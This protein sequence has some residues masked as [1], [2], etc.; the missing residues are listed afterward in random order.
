M[1]APVETGPVVAIDGDVP[2]T[3]QLDQRY[4][5]IEESHLEMSRGKVTTLSALTVVV[6]GALLAAGYPAWRIAVFV[7]LA[8]ATVALEWWLSY[9]RGRGHARRRAAL[10]IVVRFSVT[11]L[12]FP[13]T[14][15]LRSPF[16]PVIIFPVSDLVVATGWSRPVK[17][18]L[19]LLAATVL[20]L[21]LL[22]DRWFGPDLPHWAYS[23]IL[24]ALLT[25]AATWHTRYA[26]SL[27]RT[28]VATAYDLRR[29]RQEAVEHSVAR[30]RDM[31]QLA[32]KLSH[33]LKNPLAAI[34]W[35]V[36]L[37]ARSAS[38]SDSREQ[39]RVMGTEVQRMEVILKDYLSFSRPVQVLQPQALRLGA[40][41]DDVLS[42]M[43]GRAESARVALRRRGDAAV[44]ADSRKLKD[45]LFNLLGNALEATPAGGSVEVQIEEKDET[46]RIAVRDSGRGMSKEVLERLGTPFFTTREEGTGLGVAMARATF[47]QHGGSLVYASEPGRGTT[48]LGTLPLKISQ[49]SSHVAGAVG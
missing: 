47:A 40:L 22:P 11:L 8:G 20:A 48:A 21:G 19:A 46:V 38:D 42:A 33:E 24:I 30:A 44:E 29:A 2:T 5:A 39:L 18:M 6:L 35:L 10:A 4:R 15:G 14:G 16:L 27:T 1:K 13:L 37:S 9:T 49:R 25:V 7:A 23:V 34:K 17:V 45:A 12:F 26:R 43:E 3:E 41:A 28:I 36:Q 32:A 31:E